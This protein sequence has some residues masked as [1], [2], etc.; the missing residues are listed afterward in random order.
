MKHPTEIGA[1]AFIGSNTMLIAP[2][3]IGAG[4]L[5]ASGSVITKD[6][7]EDA[8]AISRA[9]QVT[10]LGRARKLFEM[11]KDCKEKRDKGAG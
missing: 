11:L 5:T 8:L 6:V 2:V 1:G 3:K 10:K 4:A 9:P 7:E